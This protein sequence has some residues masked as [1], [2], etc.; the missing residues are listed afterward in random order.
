[1]SISFSKSIKVVLIVSLSAKMSSFLHSLVWGYLPQ[2]NDFQGSLDFI[3][4]TSYLHFVKKTFKLLFDYWCLCLFDYWCFFWA[5]QQSSVACF[6]FLVVQVILNN[7]IQKIYIF[8]V[9]SFSLFSIHG[10]FFTTG[11]SIGLTTLF[12]VWCI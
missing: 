7:F 3:N 9:H 11:K 1:M 10:H 6:V 12:S 8:F 5:M 2:C 4:Q